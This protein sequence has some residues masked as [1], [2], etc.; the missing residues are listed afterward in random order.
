MGVA[1]GR[2][3]RLPGQS[4]TVGS[5]AEADNLHSEGDNLHSG[6]DNFHFEGVILHSKADHLHSGAD[7][8]KGG[9]AIAFTLRAGSSDFD[10][11]GG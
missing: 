2:T 4:I 3:D 1:N 6:A 8:T 11:S 7:P 9:E 5:I 10:M